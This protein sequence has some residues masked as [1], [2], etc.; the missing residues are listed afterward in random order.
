V[1]GERP[2]PDQVVDDP[3]ADLVEI[4]PALGDVRVRAKLLADVTDQPAHGPF[5]VEQLVPNQ[6]FGAIDQCGIV[7]HQAVRVE[8]VALLAG[9]EALA[10]LLEL[11]D[12]LLHRRIEPVRLRF[13]P[14]GLD[15]VPRN[16]RAPR[17]YGEHAPD[18]DAG[19]SG[20]SG[21]LRQGSRRSITGGSA[22][23]AAGASPRWPSRTA[24]FPAPARAVRR[25]S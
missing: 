12:R 9:P 13:H 17:V 3:V 10:D 19:R 24:L 25:A 2:L 21:Q 1:D 4:R 22:S 14:V 20:D 11:I 16:A 23:R 18:R 8:D 15:V 7:R 5:G 6:P